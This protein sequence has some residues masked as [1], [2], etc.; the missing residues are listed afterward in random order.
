[1]RAAADDYLCQRSESGRKVGETAVERQ[2]M[3]AEALSTLATRLTLAVVA[4]E[5][6]ESRA[7]GLVRLVSDRHGQLG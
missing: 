6:A 5:P 3:I 1:M 7:S 2:T 4:D